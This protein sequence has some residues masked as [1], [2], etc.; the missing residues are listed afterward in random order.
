MHGCLSNTNK[1][2]KTIGTV[3]GEE[4]KSVQRSYGVKFAASFFAC[5]LLKKPNRI[6]EVSLHLEILINANFIT[7]NV[8]VSAEKYF[9]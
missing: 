2:G 3:N 7:F 4:K 5:V 6:C 8:L 9:L 1:L